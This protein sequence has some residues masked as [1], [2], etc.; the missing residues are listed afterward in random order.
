[1]NFARLHGLQ[2]VQNSPMPR[3]QIKS[4]NNFKFPKML[5]IQ[6]IF[7]KRLPFLHSHFLKSFKCRLSDKALLQW[8]IW[9][10]ALFSTEVFQ[11]F[12]LGLRRQFVK[13]FH[14]F[15]RQI[16]SRD[17]RNKNN[18]RLLRYEFLVWFPKITNSDPLPNGKVCTNLYYGRAW[19]HL[20][21]MAR[22]KLKKKLWLL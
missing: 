9:K 1:M 17:K 12:S 8:L 14:G 13:I 15:C 11:S 10:S 21:V 3:H 6:I 2:T 16:S 7:L 5:P 4:R 22:N 20:I 18:S 19:P